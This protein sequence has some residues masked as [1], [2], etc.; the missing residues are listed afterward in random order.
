MCKTKAR[1]LTTNGARLSTLPAA[2][3][4][5][6]HTDPASAGAPRPNAKPG[7]DIPSGSQRLA[8]GWERP[9]RASRGFPSGMAVDPFHSLPHKINFQNLD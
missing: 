8:S 9:L 4:A 1:Q 5:S 3:T 2:P 6:P 7:A